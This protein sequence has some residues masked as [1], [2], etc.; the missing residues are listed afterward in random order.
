MIFY[1]AFKFQHGQ[2]FFEEK[3]YTY[4]TKKNPLFY[5]F[6]FDEETAKPRVAKH[7]ML[8]IR[9]VSELERLLGI[10]Q[11]NGLSSCINS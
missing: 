3:T 1:L 11:E 2:K 10:S 4:D 6:Q 9:T 8:S 7:N 5:S